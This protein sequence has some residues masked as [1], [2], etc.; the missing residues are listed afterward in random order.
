MVWNGAQWHVIEI[1]FK[2]IQCNGIQ[3]QFMWQVS[4]VKNEIP[5]VPKVENEIAFAPK[6]VPC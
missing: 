4:F 1:P 6:G 2:T 5:F 3:I